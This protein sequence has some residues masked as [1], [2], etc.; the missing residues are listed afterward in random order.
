M[1]YKQRIPSVVNN[2]FE[3]AGLLLPK[4]PG[5]VVKVFWLLIAKQDFFIGE[6]AGFYKPYRK[7][8][9]GTTGTEDDIVE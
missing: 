8:E 3:I 9:A 5:T 6:L 1:F 7:A 2:A 4:T